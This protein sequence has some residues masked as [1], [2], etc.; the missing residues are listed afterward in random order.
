MRKK[1]QPY[2]RVKKTLLRGKVKFIETTSL[3]DFSRM[4]A[5][6][7]M[8]AGRKKYKL[9]ASTKEIIELIREGRK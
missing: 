8:M 9:K 6:E 7:L 2:Y 4:K 5:Y 3:E 1:S